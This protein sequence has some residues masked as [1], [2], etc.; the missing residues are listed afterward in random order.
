MARRGLINRLNEDHY[1]FT[2]AHKYFLEYARD[3]NMRE[4]LN[5]EVNK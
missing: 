4:M 1:Q 3:L 5:A 2:P